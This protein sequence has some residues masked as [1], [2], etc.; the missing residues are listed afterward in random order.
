MDLPRGRLVVLSED[1]SAYGLVR[2]GS[3]QFPVT[4]NAL[5][6]AWLWVPTV[7]LV[8]IYMVLLFPDGRL[9]S[10]RWRTLAWLAGAVI[11]L[12]SVAVFLTPGPLDGLG[13]AQPVR[14]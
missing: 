2:P 6:Y 10:K 13:G 4:I 5:L 8:G 14:A 3:V 9:P 11:V 12:E 1:Y 7:G